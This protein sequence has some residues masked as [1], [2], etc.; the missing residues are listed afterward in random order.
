MKIFLMAASLRQD[1][2]NQRLAVVVSS[3]LNHFD[4]PFIDLDF[5]DFRKFDM[6][7]YDGDIESSTGLPNGVTQFIEHINSADGAIFI[8]PEY[9]YSIPGPF[10]NLIDW[11]SRGKPQ[12]WRN[13]PILMMS[14]SPALAGGSRGLLQLRIPL[15]ACGA[16][17]FPFTFSLANADEAFDVDGKLISK[18]NEKS[19]KR[20]L[21]QFIEFTH[22][23]QTCPIDDAMK[24]VH[25]D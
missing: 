16:H 3:I 25:A 5:C 7:L 23:Q 18:Q 1:S 22:C 10:K 19:L 20:L 12:P 4:E 14:A 11:V 9:N 8:S 13:K 6:P 21:L 15:I 24:S 2:C 17:V